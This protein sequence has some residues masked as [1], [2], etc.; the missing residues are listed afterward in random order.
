[1]YIYQDVRSVPIPYSLCFSLR[2]V[3]E[4]FRWTGLAPRE[5]PSPW[6]VCA[7]GAQRETFLL[8][9]Y[10][11][12]SSQSSRWFEETGLAPWEFELPVCAGIITL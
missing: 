10:W 4:M 11:P 9:T 5:P 6:R 1:M 12:E 8:T 2:S 3:F 7:V